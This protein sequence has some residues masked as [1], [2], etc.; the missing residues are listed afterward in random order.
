MPSQC[1]VYTVDME[2]LI[3]PILWGFGTSTYLPSLFKITLAEFG[4]QLCM[5]QLTYP[6][7]VAN[8]DKICN[9]HTVYWKSSTEEKF[10]NL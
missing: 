9:E 8:Q 5:Q 7:Q 4:V 10:R 1:L 3:Q 2:C 6:A